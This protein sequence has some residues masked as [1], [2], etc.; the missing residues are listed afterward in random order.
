M[1]K[2]NTTWTGRWVKTF[3][4][5]GTFDGWKWVVEKENK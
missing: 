4:K 2:P 3:K 1:S 5:D